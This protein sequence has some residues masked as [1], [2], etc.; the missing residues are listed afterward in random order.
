MINNHRPP[1]GVDVHTYG[2]NSTIEI[3]ELEMGSEELKFV[4]TISDGAVFTPN[5]VVDLGDGEEGGVLVT[6][7]HSRKVGKVGSS[8]PL[9]LVVFRLCWIEGVLTSR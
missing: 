6:N 8:S 5:A 1:V 7:D 9:A 3:F 4:R 2:A